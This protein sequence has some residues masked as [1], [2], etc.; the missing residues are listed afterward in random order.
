MPFRF[1]DMMLSSSLLFCMSLVV[2]VP[3]IDGGNILTQGDETM[4]FESIRQS[5]EEKEYFAPKLS[6]IPNPYKPP[7]LFWSGIFA[8]LL[9]S[10][11][12]ASVRFAFVLYGAFSVQLVYA[13]L[14]IFNVPK[15]SSFLVSCIFLFSLGTF[16]F[17]RLAM[18]EQGMVFSILLFLFFLSLFFTSKKRIYLI[19]SGVVLSFGFLWKGPIFLVYAN[20]ILIIAVSFGLLRFSA[21]PFVWR[22]KRKWKS[23]IQILL[24]PNL[25]GII[26]LSLYFFIFLNTTKNAKEWMN[27][28]LV[29]ENLGKFGNENQSEFRILLGVLA[30]SFPWSVFLMLSNFNSILNKRIN[31]AN[32]FSKIFVFS[33]LVIILLHFL[34]NRKEAYYVLPALA[35][36][37]VGVGLSFQS[38]KEQLISFLKLNSLF[39]IIFSFFILA[40]L[41]LFS[42]KTLLTNTA[43]GTFLLVSIIQSFTNHNKISYHIFLGIAILCFTQFVLIPTFSLPTFPKDLKNHLGNSICVLSENP[44]ATYEARQYFPKHNWEMG[45]PKNPNDCKSSGILSFSRQNTIPKNF[46]LVFTYKIWNPDPKIEFGS[47]QFFDLENYKIP[48]EYY[49]KYE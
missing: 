47:E 41:V 39:L 43:F 16:K 25:V 36:N 15:I 35:I 31:R 21:S 46:L 17:S 20:M 6:G 28:F 29:V 1:R 14:K 26:C 45:N 18:M 30:Y 27:F 24:L 8:S 40:F 22:G 49:Q 11:S 2:L 4:H 38:Q 19:I 33:S 34:P 3:G 23:S 32:L 9:S 42:P 5:L 48:V 12:T 7:M 37:F 13:I 10:F 44:W